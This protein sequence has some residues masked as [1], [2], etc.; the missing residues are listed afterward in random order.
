MLTVHNQHGLVHLSALPPADELTPHDG[1][2]GKHILNG[3]R[4]F[5]HLCQTG[6]LNGKLL[7][8]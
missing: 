1:L 8:C 3:L 6:L 5:L 7:C 2:S 4:F